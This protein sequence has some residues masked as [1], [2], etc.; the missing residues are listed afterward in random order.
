MYTLPPDTS[1][2]TPSEASP[3]VAVGAVGTRRNTHAARGA[4]SRVAGTT[5]GAAQRVVHAPAGR[6]RDAAARRPGLRAA[7]VLPCGVPPS[8]HVPRHAVQPR[9]RPAPHHAPHVSRP[10][11]PLVENLGERSTQVNSAFLDAGVL[12][13]APT[14]HPGLRSKMKRVDTRTHRRA[15]PH[16]LQHAPS[17]GSRWWCAMATSCWWSA[18]ATGACFAALGWHAAPISRYRTSL[19][20][21]RRR[22]HGCARTTVRRQ[23]TLTGHSRGV[24]CGCCV[25]L[26]PAHRSNRQLS[27][28]GGVRPPGQPRAGVQPPASL[29]HCRAHPGC[30]SVRPPCS[31]A[32]LGEGF[33]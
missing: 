17:A 21:R 32:H 26:Q 19:R 1:W 20:T 28:G 33:L 27:D 24:G 23:R 3:W 2:C 10:R 6:V 14:P 11:H 7:G 12:H 22:A 18:Y 4:A 15:L 29:A 13:Q 30:A 9:V 5:G 16:L 8:R 31:P 25:L